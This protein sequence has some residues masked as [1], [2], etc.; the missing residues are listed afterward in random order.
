MFPITRLLYSLLDVPVLRATINLFRPD[1]Q[2][3]ILS[4]TPLPSVP[5]F[6]NMATSLKDLIPYFFGRDVNDEGGQ[7]DP[8][9]YVENLNFAVDGQTYTDEDRKITATQVIFRTHLRDKALLW[10]HG[11]SSETRAS[12]QLLETAFLSRFAL[13]A[14]KEMDQTRFLNLIF[15]FKQRGRSIVE[16]TREGDQLNVE[17]PEK[18]EDVLGHQFIAGL[19]DKGKID[20]VQVYLGAGKS[21]VKYTD[22]KQ[23]VKKA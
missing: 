6:A 12:W 1:K 2:S 3:T 16:Y 7:E 14:Q 15:N 9:E 21:T 18:F 10:Y 19:D 4:S 11:L 20:L 5:P 22:A 23:A 17:C 8:A 13:A